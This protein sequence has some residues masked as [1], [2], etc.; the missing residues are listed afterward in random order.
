[1]PFRD[2][3]RRALRPGHNTPSTSTRDS[4]AASPPT[5]L[6]KDTTLNTSSSDSASDIKPVETK[7]S[8]KPVETKTSIKPVE[9]HSSFRSLMKITSRKA[10]AQKAQEEAE[11]WKD[12]PE[13]IY[14][15][16]EMPAPR[17]KR[18]PDPN[19]TA[20][21][22]AYSWGDAFGA[23]VGGKRR[24]KGSLY[25]PMGS[26]LPSRLGSI[27]SR[28]SA[29]KG[30]S[31]NSSA[32]PSRSQSVAEV[33]DEDERE[34]NYCKAFP[35]ICYRHSCSPLAN[36]SPAASRQKPAASEPTHFFPTGSTSTGTAGEAPDLILSSSIDSDS[37]LETPTLETSKTV[38]RGHLS[39]ADTSQYLPTSQQPPAPGK[40]FSEEELVRA[41]S[42]NGILDDNDL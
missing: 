6:V 29:R 32:A 35:F 28:R 5:E 17:Y 9:T 12:W 26:R 31:P 11:K 27:A 33:L 4:A 2:R 15:P 16:H 22:E 18:T 30:F 25:S 23:I 1:M 39:R 14:K 13:H 34:V 38:T 36:I 8:L 20:S 21:L 10:K 41:L 19:H 37:S 24:S 7:T 42:R 40:P 3:I